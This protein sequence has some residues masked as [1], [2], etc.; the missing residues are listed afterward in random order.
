MVFSSMI[1]RIVDGLPS[2]VLNPS[3]PK[4]IEMLR[5]SLAPAKRDAR[6]IR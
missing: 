1:V 4:H 3:Q 6:P 5:C 2:G